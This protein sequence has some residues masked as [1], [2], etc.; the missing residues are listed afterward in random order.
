MF[1]WHQKIIEQHIWTKPKIRQV[2]KDNNHLIIYF[3][4]LKKINW[5]RCTFAC[6]SVC[7][8]SFIYIRYML[9]LFWS[10]SVYNKEKISTSSQIYYQYITAPTNTNEFTYIS[11]QKHAVVH[12]FCDLLSIT[13]RKVTQDDPGPLLGEPLHSGP[14]KPRSSPTH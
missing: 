10:T 14:P 4:A 6:I 5:I 8:H 9:D 3:T 1:K 7:H 11:R 2:Q 13:G 12:L